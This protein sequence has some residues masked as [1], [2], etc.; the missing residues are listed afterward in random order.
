MSPNQSGAGKFEVLIDG[1][2]A[3]IVDL[4]KITGKENQQVVYQSGKLAAANHTITIINRGGMV[5]IDA[6]IVTK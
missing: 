1:K 4:S 5:G 2:P 3:K 6:L